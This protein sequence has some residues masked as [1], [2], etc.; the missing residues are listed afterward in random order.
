MAKRGDAIGRYLDGWAREEFTAHGIT[1]PVLRRGS[2]PG[3]ILL[4]ELPGVTPEVLTLGHRL[5]TAEFTVVVPALVGAPGRPRTTANALLATARVCLSREFR[6]LARDAERPAA[7]YLR[8]LAKH[9][10]GEAGHEGVGVIGMDVTGGLALAAATEPAVLA[11]VLSHPT[12]PLAPTRAARRDPGCSARELAEVR[13]RA[14]RG[15]LRVAGLRFSHDRRCPPER[16]LGLRRALGA[17][18]DLIEIDSGPGNPYGLS[19][20]AHHVLTTGYVDRPGHPTVLALAR[21]VNLIRSRVAPEE[22]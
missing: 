5:V 4:P 17:A 11:A 15:E 18:F 3:L 6:A 7:R 1:H 14:R 19:P 22:P 21:V 9:V 2:G 12:L 13:A 16:L 8:A 10:H 20:D